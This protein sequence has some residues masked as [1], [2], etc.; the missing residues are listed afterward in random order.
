MPLAEEMGLVANLEEWALQTAC[1]HIKTWQTSGAAL[2]ISTHVSSQLLHDHHFKRTIYR[3]LAKSK[4]APQHLTLAF[5]ESMLMQNAGQHVDALK[6]MKGMGVRMAI[7]HFGSGY[8]SLIYLEQF[9][10]DE[11]KIDHAFLKAIQTGTDDAPIITAIIAMAHSLGLT[12][13]VDGVE[14]ERQLAFLRDRGCDVYQ[15]QRFSPPVS[16]AAFTSLLSNST[17]PTPQPT[18]VG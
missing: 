9:P 5:T 17:P 15:G 13:V 1:E 8:S 3:A 12:T 4:L 7:D 10:L 14:T 11:I 16:A 2:N 6:Q 18:A